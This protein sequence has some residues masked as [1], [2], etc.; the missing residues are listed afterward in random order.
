MHFI[1]E[2]QHIRSVSRSGIILRAGK[3][4]HA[5]GIFLRKARIEQIDDRHIESVEPHHRLISRVAMIMKCPRR[6]NDEIARM[7]RDLLAVDRRVG[8]LA[9][10]N[11][12]QGRGR[13]PVAGGYLARQDQL[14][15]GIKTGCNLGAPSNTWVLQHQHAAFRFVRGNQRPGLHQQTA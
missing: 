5:L 11:E 8:P 13:V 12:T 3:R 9:L 1:L 7:H 6:R 4:L 2:R 15:A 14:Q 10:N